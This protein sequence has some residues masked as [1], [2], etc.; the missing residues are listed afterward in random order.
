[1]VGDSGT[2]GTKGLVPAPAAGAAAAGKFLKADGTYAIPAGTSTGTVTTTGSPSSGNLTKFSGASSVTS[3]DLSG[4]IT[5]SGTLAATIAN[6]AVTNTKAANMA[7]S[8]I[9]GRAVGAGTGDPTDLTATQATAI[10]NA[11]VGDSGSGGTKGLVP[12]PGSGDSAA[13]KFLKADGTFAIPGVTTGSPTGGGYVLVNSWTFSIN[14]TEVDFNNLGSYSEIMVITRGISKSV[15][16]TLAIRLSTDNGSSFFAGAS[17]YQIMGTDGT[18]A[19]ASSMSLYTTNTT[20]ARSGL[21]QICGFNVGSTPKQMWCA[22]RS[23]VFLF[24]GTLNALDAIR[25]F[26]ANGG[27]MTAGNIYVLGR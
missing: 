27:N 21:M 5:T 11:V 3:G 26:P 20:A 16:G 10:L 2:G 14:V 15:S 19:N 8:T 18:E 22:N 25:L 23:S 4:D 1:M 24:V 7:D 12:A 9:K 6:D 13:G 17:D